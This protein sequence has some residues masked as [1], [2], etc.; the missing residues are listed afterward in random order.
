MHLHAYLFLILSYL[1]FYKIIAICMLSHTHKYSIIIPFTIEMFIT[2]FVYMLQMINMESLVVFILNIT[3]EALLSLTYL[4][5]SVHIF[6]KNT[7]DGKLRKPI[8]LAFS[9]I[10]ITTLFQ[11]IY[12]II[13]EL[14]NHGSKEVVIQIPYFTSFIVDFLILFIFFVIFLLNII[15]SIHYNQKLKTIVLHLILLFIASMKSLVDMN[16]VTSMIHIS[17]TF[18]IMS[19]LVLEICNIIVIQTIVSQVYNTITISRTIIVQK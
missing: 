11:I 16:F 3:R 9:T 2:Y 7:Q 15:R 14:G 19:C 18:K 12:C 5:I 8:L 17:E 13:T 10:L 1:T 4:G 6:G